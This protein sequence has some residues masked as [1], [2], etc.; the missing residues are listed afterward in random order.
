MALQSHWLVHKNCALVSLINLMKFCFNHASF[1]FPAIGDWRSVI[2]I[3]HSPKLWFSNIYQKFILTSTT[4]SKGQYSNSIEVYF[5]IL[6]SLLQKDFQ[7]KSKNFGLPCIEN[8]LIFVPFNC[9]IC[10]SFNKSFMFASF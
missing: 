1:Q 4:K 3:I 5:D 9:T 8:T 6:W 10:S 2:V 7:Q